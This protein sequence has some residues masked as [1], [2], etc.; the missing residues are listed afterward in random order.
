MTRALGRNLTFVLESLKS[1]DIRDIA[2][3]S[4]DF[5]RRL[6]AVDL[7][8]AEVDAARPE[9]AA[10]V[11][12]RHAEAPARLTDRGALPDHLLEQ[13]GAWLPSPDEMLD[14]QGG[15]VLLHGGLQDDHILTTAPDDP[16]GFRPTAVLDFGDSVIGHPYFELGPAWW[17]W[18]NADRSYSDAFLE[19]AQLPGWGEPGFAR[20]AM[21][22]TLIRCA[23]NPKPPPF[24]DQARD[25]DELAELGFGT[26]R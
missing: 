22:W 1:S 15:A 16:R 23:W 6:H 20:M 5:A 21:A 9:F 3:W 10:L 25:L 12:Q 8:T 17:T 13:V 19:A 24:L 4:G 2:S 26:G 14:G 7:E 11:T 18:L